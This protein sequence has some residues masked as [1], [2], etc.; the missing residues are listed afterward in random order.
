MIILMMTVLVPQVCLY[1]VKSTH[2]HMDDFSSDST[3][4]SHTQK[5]KIHR[6]MNYEKTHESNVQ[7]A[8][9]AK[10]VYVMF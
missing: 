8:S 2:S 7:S 1:I 4:I 10:H 5:L 3:H 9:A 6:M